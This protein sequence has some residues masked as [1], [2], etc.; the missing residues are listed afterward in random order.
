M[1]TNRTLA[2]TR[3][4]RPRPR[5]DPRA[6]RLEELALE[7]PARDVWKAAT[8]PV[9]HAIGGRKA[10][11]FTLY[12]LRRKDDRSDPLVS[13]AR[14]MVALH[15][16]GAADAD[17]RRFETYLASVRTALV[18]GTAVRD[19]DTLEVA[20]CE[21]EAVENRTSL[22]LRLPGGMTPVS[23]RAAAAANRDEA[24]LQMERAD[25]MERRA[26]Q[27]EREQGPTPPAA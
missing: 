8:D 24:L 21:A 5:S 14:Q 16:M 18:C 2:L 15:T 27:L 3:E 25:A 1:H 20:E 19:L 6:I 22:T 7:Q 26:R 10:T 9:M 17:L 12:R 11:S 13:V 23:L 4:P